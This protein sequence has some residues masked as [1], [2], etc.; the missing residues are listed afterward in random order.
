MKHRKMGEGLGTTSVSLTEDTPPQMSSCR[1]TCLQ[2]VQ[3]SL[4]LPIPCMP[5]SE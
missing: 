4:Q 1:R 2:A 3:V 5:I